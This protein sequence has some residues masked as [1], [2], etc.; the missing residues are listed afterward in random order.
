MEYKM[1]QNR[2]KKDQATQWQRGELEQ[3]D[4]K[5]EILKIICTL[6]LGHHS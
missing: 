2:E 6:L 1:R 4:L 5:K 3:E